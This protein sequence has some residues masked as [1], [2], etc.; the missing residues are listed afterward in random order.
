MLTFL[1]EFLNYNMILKS[2]PIHHHFHSLLDSSSGCI[3]HVTSAFQ[4]KILSLLPF[5]LVTCRRFHECIDRESE[6][7]VTV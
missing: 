1:Q 2:P 7:V 5:S 3:L 4:I 6:H